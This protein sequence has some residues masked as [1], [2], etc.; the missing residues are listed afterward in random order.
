LAALDPAADGHL[1]DLPAQPCHPVPDPAPVSLD[2]R[3]TGPA[4][5]DAAAASLPAGTATRP[6]RAAAAADTAAGRALPG[7]CPPCC[8]RAGRRC[9]GSARCGRCPCPPRSL[10]PAELAGCQLA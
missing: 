2:L 3:L 10:E 9:P 8:G 4:R 7:P 1:R 6:S 5:P